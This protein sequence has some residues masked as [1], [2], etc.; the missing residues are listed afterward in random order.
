M[1]N[2]VFKFLDAIPQ[3][4]IDSEWGS[5]MHWE[6]PLCNGEVEG[7]KSSY[8]GHKHCKCNKCNFIFME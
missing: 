8:N 2:N 3:S 7:K 4:F 6:C 5:V 1:S